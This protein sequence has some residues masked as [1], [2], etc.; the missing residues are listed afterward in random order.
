V[1]GPDQGEIAVRPGRT[2][3]WTAFGDGPP[4]LLVNGYAVPTAIVHG[5]LDTVVLPDNAEVLA[6]FHPG[7]TVEIRPAC[8][9][10]VMAQEPEPVSEA[11]LAATAG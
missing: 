4:L 5:G 8:A 6:R 3:A 1:R 11:I 10:A 7:A 2:I 9:H